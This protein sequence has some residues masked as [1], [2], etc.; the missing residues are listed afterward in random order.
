MAKAKKEEITEVTIRYDLF[1]LPTAQHKAG[2][3]GLVLAI[4]SLKNRSDN[5]PAAIPP[6]T[7]PEIVEGPTLSEAVIRF[8]QTSF[9]QLMNDIYDA[10]PT[11]SVQEKPRKNKK[12]KENIPWLDRAPI[13]VYNKKTEQTTTKE[14]YVYLDAVPPAQSDSIQSR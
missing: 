11:R 13:E 4:R 1:D 14:G 6:E 7:V 8:T 5:D 10:D 12:T 3:A 2:L 9:T